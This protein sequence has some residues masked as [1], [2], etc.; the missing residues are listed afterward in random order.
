MKKFFL[1]CLILLIVQTAFTQEKK[2]VTSKGATA[3]LF[4]FNGLN[5]LN[6]LN[7]RNGIGIKYFL[8]PNLALRIGIQFR[9]LSETTPA[10]PDTNQ[11]GVDGEYSSNTFGL[12][13]A[14]EWHLKNQRISPFVGGGLNFFLTSSEEKELVVWYKSNPGLIT[15]TTTKTSGGI[16]YGVFALAGVEVF[17]TRSVS[18][19]G[20]YQLSYLHDSSDEIET[21]IEAIQGSDPQL[22]RTR[23]VKGIGTNS[24]G[25]D[26]SGVLILAIY[27]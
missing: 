21:T 9:G 15:R 26:A 8:Q 23:K 19:T 12:S 27:F 1:L 20:E 13:G 24:Y 17:I 7:Y 25:I 16:S 14:M 4:T 10:N 5:N 18:L 11:Y 22:P 6:L 2:Y 3:L